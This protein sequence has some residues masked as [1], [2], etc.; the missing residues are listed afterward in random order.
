MP[1]AELFARD[2]GRF[3]RF[4]REQAG[5]FL[6]FSRQRLD[7]GGTIAFSWDATRFTRP[8]MVATAPFASD[9]HRRHAG[10][11]GLIGNRDQIEQQLHLIVERAVLLAQR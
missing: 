8:E 11:I 1:V 6:D 2:P 10:E 3:E 7:E 4:S 9:H 5:L